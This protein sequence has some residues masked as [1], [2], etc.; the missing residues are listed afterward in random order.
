M[1]D[2]NNLVNFG[3]LT[4]KWPWPL[5]L[6]FNSIRAVVNEHVH[7]KYH[8]AECRDS[9]VIVY[10]YFFALSRNGKESENTVLWPWPLT[11]RLKVFVRLSCTFVQNFVKLRAA[12]NELLR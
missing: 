10:R 6:K 1:F 11:L 7:A 12:V 5:T 9:Q 3:P 8:Q 2:E 4:K